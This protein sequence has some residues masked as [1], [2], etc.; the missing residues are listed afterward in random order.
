MV[1]VQV[2][3]QESMGIEMFYDLLQ[4]INSVLSCIQNKE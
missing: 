4:E 1:K 3:Y 2:V